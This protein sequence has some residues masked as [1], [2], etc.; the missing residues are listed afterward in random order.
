MVR[1]LEGAHS[2][3]DQS[4]K[5]TTAE[6]AIARLQVEAGHRI[7]AMR[8]AGVELSQDHRD[9]K[10]A[11]EDSNERNVANLGKYHCTSRNHHGDL[12]VSSVGVKYVSAVRKNLLWE[13]RFDDVKL[14]EKVGT[15]EGLLFVDTND[16]EFR[17]SG[18]KLRNEV[19]T[20]II[21]YSGLRWQV[22]G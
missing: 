21:G 3:I 7:E 8:K 15:G 13:V 5:R 11:G 22:T 19:F 17:V 12:C 18:L 10:S 1:S 14:L 6:W 16:E 9:E 2:L 4:L 20:Q